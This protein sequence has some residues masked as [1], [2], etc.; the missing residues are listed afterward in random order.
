MK[1]RNSIANPYIG[2]ESVMLFVAARG[3]DGGNLNAL[4]HL[5]AANH[6][7]QLQVDL[8]FQVP[9]Q[10]FEFQFKPAARPTLI[11]QAEITQSP[12]ATPPG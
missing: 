11:P 1:C 2:G 10:V 12:L 9:E 8:A 3:P 6:S 4:T 5:F 7:S